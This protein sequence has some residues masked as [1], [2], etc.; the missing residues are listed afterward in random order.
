MK[1]TTG[2]YSTYLKVVVLR[3]V[4]AGGLDQTFYI[5]ESFC[6][7]KP[8]FVGLRNRYLRVAE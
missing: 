3:K 6:L 4:G 7:V 8:S 5:Y 1:R 2:Y